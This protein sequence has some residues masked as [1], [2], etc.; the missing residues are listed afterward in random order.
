MQQPSMSSAVPE[1]TNDIEDRDG[2]A[3]DLPDFGWLHGSLLMVANGEPLTSSL[4]IKIVEFLYQS[5]MPFTLYPSRVFYYKVI[6]LFLERYPHL[7]DSIGSGFSDVHTASQHE[8]ET[9][10]ERHEQWLRSEGK[11]TDPDEFQ[12][13]VRMAATHRSRAA[14]L[15][16]LPV[17]VTVVKY[18][19]IMASGRFF[20]EF[21]SAT[22]KEALQP[23]QRGVEEVIRLTVSGI[24]RTG[25][26]LQEKAKHIPHLED[27]GATRKK[28]MLAVA[29]LNIL[30]CSLRETSALSHLFVHENVDPMPMIPCVRFTGDSLDEAQHM[31]LHVDGTRLFRVMDAE[32]G[33]AAIF[34]AYW[35]FQAQ[36]G[37]EVTNV[38]TFIERQ[39][40]KLHSTK[41]KQ[42]VI[43]LVSKVV[44]A[45]T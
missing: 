35:I 18:P 25:S 1:K 30:G 41:A 43:K 19:Y 15:A 23:V 38:M 44:R 21:E 39:W 11:K 5:V 6:S 2:K 33:I 20:N 22:S 42:Q 10:I 9:S 12:I 27:V 34:A 16:T 45:T 40:Y 28:H 7:A 37:K 31:Y 14:D 36:Y 17:T 26:P 32:E 3:Y 8:D 29:A 13:K 24:I 4:E